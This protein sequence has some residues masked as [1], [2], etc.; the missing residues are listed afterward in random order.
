MSQDW[1][2]SRR[3]PCLFVLNNTPS[4]SIPD[5][6]R[7]RVWAAIEQL[8]YRPNT[9][10]QGLRLQRSG[11]LGFITDEI[12]IT[13]YAGKIFEGAQDL[14]WENNKFLLL[15]NTKANLEIEKAAVEMLLD[16]QVEGRTHAKTTAST[17]G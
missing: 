1:P 2:K 11:V 4:V 13:P 17:A 9:L 15:V 7:Q 10:A 14:A 6:T 3:R 8:G 12:A 16:R 5:E